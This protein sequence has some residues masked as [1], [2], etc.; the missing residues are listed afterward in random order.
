M[1]NL[2]PA[3]LAL[4]LAASAF[5]LPRGVTHGTGLAAT[6]SNWPMIGSDPGQSYFN[7]AEHTLNPARLR[8]RWRLSTASTDFVVANGGAYMLASAAPGQVRPRLVDGSTGTIRRIFPTM[9]AQFPHADSLAWSAGTLYV[10]GE[11]LT[12][13]NGT[14]GKVLFRARAPQQRSGGEFQYVL[15]AH[16]I[17]YT[18]RPFG[19]M[20]V[21]AV[22][23]AGSTGRILW[24]KQPLATAPVVAGDRVFLSGTS[25]LGGAFSAG[26]GTSLWSAPEH[27]GTGIAWHAGSGRIFRTIEL[28]SERQPGGQLQTDVYTRDGRRLWGVSQFLPSAVA[29]NRVYGMLGGPQQRVPAALDAAT[30]RVLWAYRGGAGSFWFGLAVANRVVYAVNGSLGTLHAIDAFDVST[31]AL[32]RR[33]KL[34]GHVDGPSNLEIADGMLYVGVTQTSS[35]ARTSRALLLAYGK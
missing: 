21:Q 33:I 23:I 12:A 8:L 16:G 27:N 6:A 20:P 11:A 7:S 24:A 25:D 22:A 28:R 2:L 4:A 10:G 26:A 17:V 15:P 35:D 31:G 19:G 5:A 30:G 29:G 9:R 34:P 14:T 3:S 32:I 18:A 13:L 1:K